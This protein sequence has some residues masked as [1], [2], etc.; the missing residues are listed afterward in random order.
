MTP[1]ALLLYPVIGIWLAIT[2]QFVYPILKSWGVGR[3]V[4]EVGNGRCEVVAELQACEKIVLH[5]ATGSLYLACSTR[6]SRIHWTPATS[7]LNASGASQ[8]D[9]VA[10]YD[11]ASGNQRRLVVEN[12]GSSRGLSL[13]GMDV[14]PSSSDPSVLYVYLVSH[15]KPLN[16]RAEK[17][18]ADSVIEIF[19]ATVGG[20]NLVHLHTVEDPVILTPNDIVGSSD[21]LSFYFTN[22]QGSKTGLARELEKIGLAATSVGYCHVHEGCKI[23][24]DRMPRNNGIVAA[25]NGTVYVANCVFGEVRVLQTQEDHT[26]RLVEIISVDRP[27]DNLSMDE[28]GHIWASGFPKVLEFAMKA[29]T[30]LSA[31]IPSSAL[32]ISSIESEGGRTYR[33]DKVFED[34]G[35]IASGSTSVAYDSQ[36]NRLFIHGITAPHLTVCEL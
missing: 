21:G 36:R 30:N 11:P 3:A 16:G 29:F 13:H 15:R 14:V 35:K 1:R 6:S 7:H 4:Q 9:Y 24:M 32:R 12:F 27:M 20:G 8:D 10:V 17:V 33:V 34:S 19:K 25:A 5:K 31:R 23:A 26:L 2:F 22:D 28:E 18:G